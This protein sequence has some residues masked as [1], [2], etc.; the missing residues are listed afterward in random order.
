MTIYPGKS[1]PWAWPTDRKNSLTL[2]LTSHLRRVK[3]HLPECD[4]RK[5][6][7]LSLGQQPIRKV[8]NLSLA[9]YKRKVI[10]LGLV[11]F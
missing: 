6:F 7:F 8:I 11:S 3:S 5:V 4:H 9:G 1:S 2:S 10:Y